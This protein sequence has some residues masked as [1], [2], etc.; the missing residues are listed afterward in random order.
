M[1]RQIDPLSVA[2]ILGIFLAA[3]AGAPFGFS[4]DQSMPNMPMPPTPPQEQA[5]TPTGLTLGELEQMALSNN[6]TLAQAA[7]EIRAA[8]SRKPR[9][10]VC[11]SSTPSECSTTR[12]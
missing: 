1:K 8:R 6:P 2:L 10:N 11:V 12:R 3:L 5:R 4:Q 7:A 9:S